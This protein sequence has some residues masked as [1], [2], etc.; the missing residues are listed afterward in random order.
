M[1]TLDDLLINA[2]EHLKA[3]RL[4]EAEGMF[5]MALRIMDNH[6]DALHLLGLVRWKQG[7]PEEAQGLIERAVQIVPDNVGYR[8]NLG[9][10]FIV[11]LSRL[12]DG[13]DC[14]ERAS[15]MEPANPMW[16]EFLCIQLFNL[17]TERL[18]DEDF[19]QAAAACHRCFEHVVHVPVM[20]TVFY[21]M[22]E[23]LV[24]VALM[25]K[26]TELAVATLIE[27]NKYDFR[28]LPPSEID[29]FPID[30]LDFHEWCEAFGFKSIAW[31]EPSQPEPPGLL[32][33][34]P[35]CLHENIKALFQDA[36]RRFG[37]ALG[38]NIEVVQGMYVEGFYNTF[39]LADR[40]AMLMDKTADAFV[41]HPSKGPLMG[42]VPEKTKA[43]FRLARPDFREIEFDEPTIFVPSNTNYAHFLIDHIP[44]VMACDRVAE[45]RGLPIAFFDMRLFQYEMLEY[46]GISPDRVIDVKQRLAPVRDKV[47]Y[48]FRQ[49][50]VPSP[51]P[52]AVAYR[53]VREAFLSRLPKR[54]S[55]LPRR[56]FLSRRN[57]Y[58]KHRILNDTEVG[59][60]LAGRGFTVVTPDT[61]S[62]AETVE[63]F[64]R[65]EIV[66]TPVGA[67]MLNYVFLPPQATIIFLN[68]PEF[69]HSEATWNHFIRNETVLV[70]TFRQL[71]C[72][73]VGDP[74]TFPP[75]PLLRLEIPIDVDL[76]ALGRLVDE[77]EA[78]L[79]K[80]GRA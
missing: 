63:M 19:E 38:A 75:T 52:Y 28:E 79:A 44:Q 62:I 7:F 71:T 49:A 4:G 6:P 69:F 73:F 67:G 14:F 40:R 66:V 18:K 80:T 60:Y 21:E 48:R 51:V 55:K 3:D 17:V 11:A 74:G 59:E 70:G 10:L 56:I 42:V 31:R 68:N 64:S 61:L 35:E 5:R 36:K 22:L 50:V 53:W 16:R 13:I 41:R 2:V 32:D 15:R 37:V 8:I 46:L 9:R 39:V 57:A 25:S 23:R 26:D 12:E 72:P 58:P 29:V 24:Q 1:M 65:A 20:S 54:K 47:I 27:K 45:T 78:R 30:L 33:N 76:A 77:A 43:V 34:Y